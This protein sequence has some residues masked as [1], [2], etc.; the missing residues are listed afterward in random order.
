MRVSLYAYGMRLIEKIGEDDVNGAAA[1][2]AYR[3]F[4]ALFPFFIFLAA[5]SGFV[6]STFNI[7]DP[8]T[9]IMELLGDSL[10]EDASSVLE[11]QLRTVTEQRNAGL[12]SI[13]I[14]GAIWA[15]SGGISALMK[16]M[17]RMYS[18]GESRSRWQRYAISLGLTFLSAGVLVLSFVVFFAGQ[19]YGPELADE[20]GLESTAR[21]LISL[22]LW[23]ATLIMVMFAVAFL[24]WLA[25]NAGLNMRWISPGAVFFTVTW[26]IV[27][28]GFGLYISNF[29]SYN[30]TYGTL[31]GVVV[32]LIWFYLTAF[33]LLVGAEINAVI[34]EKET[35][36]K[37][38]EGGRQAVA[39]Q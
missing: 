2:M 11:E 12:L 28:F 26:L 7:E 10:P 5:L 6:A 16:N 29:G 1:E 38:P 23:P 22:A 36:T 14:L 34:A 3:F 19:V 9:E 37:A 32:L 15:T 25:P 20:V 4:L 18:V 8:S 13:G 27:S 31:G 35:G 17:N 39:T 30:A 24:Y 33:L 21:T